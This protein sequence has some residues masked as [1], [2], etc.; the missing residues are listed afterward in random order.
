RRKYACVRY[1]A[2]YWLSLWRA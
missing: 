2:S 1:H